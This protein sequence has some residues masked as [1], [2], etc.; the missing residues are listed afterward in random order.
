MKSLFVIVLLAAAFSAQAQKQK[1]R[2]YCQAEIGVG[3]TRL[4]SLQY[5]ERW[6][7]ER[8][9][10]TTNVGRCMYFMAEWTAAQIDIEN[11]EFDPRTGQTSIQKCQETEIQKRVKKILYR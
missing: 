10:P 11:A 3:A 6:F 5:Q 2:I 1:I 7:R 9:T 4:D 8:A